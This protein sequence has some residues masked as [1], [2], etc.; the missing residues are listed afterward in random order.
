MA[1]DVAP[2]ATKDSSVLTVMSETRDRW[3]RV[4]SIIR[5]LKRLYGVTDLQLAEALG[6]TRQTVQGRLSGSTQ[7]TPWELAGFAAY[8]GVPVEVLMTAS[9]D[10]VLRWILDHPEARPDHFT[11]QGGQH[12][13]WNAELAGNAV[14]GRSA[15]FRVA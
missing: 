4:P 10:D 15:R 8:F 9:A 11:D 5:R 7:I 3:V 6:L 2:V 13:T 1:K 14:F 12:F